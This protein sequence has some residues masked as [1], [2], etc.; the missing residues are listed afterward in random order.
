M[1]LTGECHS[2]SSRKHTENSRSNEPSSEAG[3]PRAEFSKS[4]RPTSSISLRRGRFPRSAC[5]RRMKDN[6]GAKDS[7]DGVGRERR[8]SPAHFPMRKRGRIRNVPM[9]QPVAFSSI[10][11]QILSAMAPITTCPTKQIPW[12]NAPTPVIRGGRRVPKVFQGMKTETLNGEDDLGRDVD[13]LCPVPRF[14]RESDDFQ[15]PIHAPL[16][17]WR[18]NPSIQLCNSICNGVHI[19][20]PKHQNSTVLSRLA[21]K[22]GETLYNGCGP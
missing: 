2:Q 3:D 21:A 19:Y 14:P 17:C 22:L 15:L 12:S 8:E 16:L 6:G 20:R 18:T 4:G 10:F 11:E 7:R 1:D 5:A 13:P 9:P